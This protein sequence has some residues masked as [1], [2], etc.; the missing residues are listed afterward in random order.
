MRDWDT[1][2]D[3]YEQLLICSNN[4]QQLA[5]AYNAQQ[6]QLNQTSALFNHQQ[7]T[8]Q[9]LVQQ[10]NRLTQIA[11]RHRKELTD[12]RTQLDLIHAGILSKHP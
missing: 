7:D 12:L 4:I 10:N 5:A 6:E 11:D 9:Q 1:N 3:P 2:W 8:I